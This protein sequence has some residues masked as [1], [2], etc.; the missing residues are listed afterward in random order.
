MSLT[1]SQNINIIDISDISNE[2]DV[3]QLEK[4]FEVQETNRDIYKV[5]KTH[6][7][8]PKTRN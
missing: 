1:S 2:N 7:P 8:R 4:I 5:Q 3:K 6:L